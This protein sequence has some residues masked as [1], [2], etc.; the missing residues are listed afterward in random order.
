MNQLSLIDLAFVLFESGDT[1]MHVTGLVHLQPPTDSESA[2][3]ACNLYSQLLSYSEVKSPFNWRLN[4]SLTEWPNW[5]E[6]PNVDITQHVHLSMLPQPGSR[7]Q[8]LD[9]VGRIH[10]HQLD[11]F[12]PLWEMWVIGGLENNQVV[13]CFKVHHAIADGM[14]VGKLFDFCTSQ[15][16]AESGTPFWQQDLGKSRKR[17]QEE[18]K[19]LITQ[20]FG[21]VCELKRQLSASL[22]LVSLGTGMLSKLF[23]GKRPDLK[24]PFT[25]PKT[26]FNQKH[27]KSRAV[28]LGRLPVSQFRQISRLT[29]ASLNDVMLCVCDIALNRHLQDHRLCL[30]KPLVALMPIDLRE[31]GAVK[32]GGNKFAVGLVELGHALDTPTRRLAAIQ[33]STQDVKHQAQEVSP[34]GYINYSILVNGLAL[35]GGKLNINHVVPPATN[36]IISNVPG[37]AQRRYFFGAEV[38]ECYPL[39]LLIPGQTINITMFGYDD[40]LHFGLVSCPSSLPHA[41]KIPDYLEEA[42]ASLDQDVMETAMSAVNGGLFDP[43]ADD[44]SQ[45]LAYEAEMLLAELKQF[46]VSPLPR[47]QRRVTRETEPAK[48]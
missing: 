26:P 45:N 7:E 8:L 33:Q 17:Q 18:N 11:R 27:H 15:D 48:E 32:K 25:A 6:V 36:L 20:L 44:H 22:G 43:L 30:E 9:L 24:V 34:G 38:Q 14:K 41:E 23:C 10:S 16:P 31:E 40:H 3:F 5:Q 42:L 47:Q 13:I 29:G 35:L 1:P 39:S 4:L 2:E 12:R 21:S 37:P 28:G 46:K 19:Q